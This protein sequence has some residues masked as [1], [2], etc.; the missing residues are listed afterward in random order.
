MQVKILSQ[1][2]RKIIIY[3]FAG[4]LPSALQGKF[5]VQW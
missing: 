4:V 5:Q 2:V 1:N 3:L